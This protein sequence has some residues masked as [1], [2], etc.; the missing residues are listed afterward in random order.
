L[1]HADPVLGER[2]CC[3]LVLGPAQPRS[4]LDDLRAFLQA[5]DVAK[6]KWP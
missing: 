6:T 4:P 2:A 3:F 5:R 1:C